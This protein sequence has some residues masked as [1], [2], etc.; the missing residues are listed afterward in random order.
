[1][2]LRPISSEVGIAI[3]AER[4][5]ALASASTPT[6]SSGV[7]ATSPIKR[8]KGEAGEN[9]QSAW[10]LSSRRE[11]NP[12]ADD[13][14]E[15]EALGKAQLKDGGHRHQV[16]RDVLARPVIEP[17]RLSIKL[18]FMCSYTKFTE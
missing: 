10:R 18:S 15:P 16:D 14:C 1:M 2:L 8:R 5:R 12:R 13:R 6:T 17:I 7:A 11:A 4:K 3:S 9:G